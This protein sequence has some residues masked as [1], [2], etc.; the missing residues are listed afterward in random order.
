M[1][2][3]YCGKDCTAC[4]YREST[5][6]YGCKAG[7]GRLIYGDCEI[8][9]CCRAK[10]HADC[11]T[12]VQKDYCGQLKCRIRM[13]EYRRQKQ[14]TEAAIRAEHIRTAPFF[15]KWLGVLF[16]LFIVRHAVS[17]SGGI[18]SSF[19]PHL[20]LPCAILNFALSIGHAV[21]LLILSREDRH[22]YRLAGIFVILAAIATVALESVENEIILLLLAIPTAV[23]SIF[24]EHHQYWGHIE[25]L[26]GVNDVM[27]Q[28]WQ[29]LWKWRWIC[30]ALVFGGTST[31]SLI[32]IFPLIA[33]IVGLFG[34]AYVGVYEV[35]YLYRS[36]HAY[37]DFS[38]EGVNQ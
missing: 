31:S 19:L 34:T 2:Q 11:S 20:Q 35:I 4:E 24:G 30:I 27:A 29:D 22:H 15:G 12:C 14:E 17:V 9:K 36:A 13:P 3:T 7:P 25:N 33:V 16:W 28:L 10:G 1:A 21:F 38:L 18:L 8:A 5:G 23:L 6:C 37:R 32:P 26:H